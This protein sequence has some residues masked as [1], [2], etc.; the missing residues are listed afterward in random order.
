MEINRTDGTLPTPPVEN[1]EFSRRYIKQNHHSERHHFDVR[2]GP[3]NNAALHAPESGSTRRSDSR[4][5]NG[6]RYES[7]GRGEIVEA[8]SRYKTGTAYFRS[9][10]VCSH[11]PQLRTVPARQLAFDWLRPR[12]GVAQ[13]GP[14]TEATARQ[15]SVQNF[16]SRIGARPSRTRL[17]VTT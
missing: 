17:A 14:S 1:S 16:A 6:H 4:V 11:S 15:L 7:R 5:G 2:P 9:V 3:S 10:L 13:R 12:F 8:G